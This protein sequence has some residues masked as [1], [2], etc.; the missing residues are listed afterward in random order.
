[1]QAAVLLARSFVP[2]N[3]V[4]IVALVDPLAGAIWTAAVAFALLAL[5]VDHGEQSLVASARANAGSFGTLA[6]VIVAGA[7]LDRAGLFRVLAGWLTGDRLAGRWLG[8]AVL[9]FTAL[10]SGLVNLDVA[11]V[12]APPVALL[13]AARARLA[14][15]P[16]L[17]AVALVANATSFLLPTAN[18]TNLLVLA[19]APLGLPAYLVEGVPAWIAI[20][21]ATIACLAWR[22]P[23]RTSD[24]A[25]P[26]PGAEREALPL[27]SGLVDLL[28]MFILASALRAVIGGGLTLPSGFLPGFLSTAALA[29]GLDNLPVAGAVTVHA[30]AGSWGAILALAM[31]PNLLP[32]GSVATL[33]CRRATLSRGAPFPLGR[34]CLAGAALLPLQLAAG[35]LALRLSGVAG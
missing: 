31:G 9:F 14:E 23:R 5:A 22:L 32:W 33:I 26:S 24:A 12:V 30:G 17:V 28:P 35:C 25:S 10:V 7:V 2:A 4:R 6:A 20:T 29:S 1:M 13:V 15:G 18:M 34:F 3:A 11:A 16:L 21:T 19:R 8:A 27:L